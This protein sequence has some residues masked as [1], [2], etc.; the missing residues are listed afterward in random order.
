MKKEFQASSRERIK[1]AALVVTGLIIL[2]VAKT[3]EI[4]VVVAGLTYFWKEMLL[5]DIY[6]G[7]ALNCNVSRANQEEV[8][9]LKDFPRLI[10]LEVF[11]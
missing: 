7:S 11:L 1:D 10:V 5:P 6:S 2:T 8:R 3:A 4:C 9:A